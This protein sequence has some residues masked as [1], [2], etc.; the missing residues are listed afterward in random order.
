MKYKT[1]NIE[2]NVYLYKKIVHFGTDINLFS[3]L[4]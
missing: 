4:H 2:V 3:L 1:N